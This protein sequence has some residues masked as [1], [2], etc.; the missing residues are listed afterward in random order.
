MSA[1]A[2]TPGGGA[3]DEEPVSPKSMPVATPMPLATSQG[4]ELKE[5]AG[6]GSEAER[7]AEMEMEMETEMDIEGHTNSLESSSLEHE[8][9]QGQELG[10]DQHQARDT[11]SSPLSPLSVPRTSH[12]A[13]QATAA[14]TASAPAAQ[15]PPN[16]SIN[17]AT[18]Q[19]A[20]ASASA[21]VGANTD[22]ATLPSF[23]MHPMPEDWEMGLEYNAT[24]TG[25]AQFDEEGIDNSDGGNEG[26]NE[27][28]RSSNADKEGEKIMKGQ[29]EG[30]GGEN[31]SAAAA[32]GSAQDQSGSSGHG[33]P[34][35]STHGGAMEEKTAEKETKEGEEEVWGEEDAEGEEELWGEEDAEGEDED[36]EAYGEHGFGGHTSHSLQ[37]TTLDA[38]QESD[39]APDPPIVLLPELGEGSPASPGRHAQS[40]TPL[41]LSGGTIAASRNT[42]AAASQGPAPVGRVIAGQEADVSTPESIRLIRDFDSM[43]DTTA[44]SSAM[45]T[46]S[47]NEPKEQTE[48]TEPA[49]G[50]EQAEQGQQ[51]RGQEKEEAGQGEDRTI[52]TAAATQGGDE[53]ETAST[54]DNPASRPAKRR[55]I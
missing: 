6:L 12:P 53:G 50:M 5:R 38:S 21:S 36:L 10:L 51:Q 32:G 28:R 31:E 35:P 43:V 33:E 15:P 8:K 34:G 11:T 4:S 44:G 17:L 55:K 39:Q 9:G 1:P 16:L 45:N 52:S 40:S 37:K 49:Q 27:E 14:S 29:E 2:P 3:C 48:R 13:P 26:S 18:Q 20:N 54:D 46:E 7:E 24:E 41:S 30:D 22:P 25:M 47:G 23:A 19:S 42:A